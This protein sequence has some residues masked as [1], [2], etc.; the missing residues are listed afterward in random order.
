MPRW[1]AL[2][3]I[4]LVACKQEPATQPPPREEPRP[5]AEAQTQAQAQAQA[6]AAAEA[7][8][9]KAKAEGPLAWIHD[10]YAAALA[11]AKARDLPLVLDLWAPWCHTCLS[12][13]QTV[14]TDPSFGP[15]AKRFVFAALDTDRDGNAAAVAK[16]PLSA[17]PTFYVVSPEE[18]VLA[19]FTGAASVAQFHAFLD[20][21]AR[22]RGGG[23]AGA[24]AHLLAAERAIAAKD[25]EAAD[26]ELTAALAA[27]PADWARR[28]DALVSL[29]GAKHKRGDIEGCV[30]LAERS[31]NDT[32]S[33]ASAT[34]FLYHAGECAEA[35]GKPAQEGARPDAAAAAR[36]KKLRQAAVTRWQKLVDDPA[37]PLSIDDRSDA[38][39]N[40]RTMLLALDRKAEAKAVAER[41][42]QLLD[43]TAAKAPTPLAAMTY[44]WPRAEV[45]AFLE[46]PL[47]LVPALEKSVRDL[48]AEYDPPA[49]LG[50]IYLKGGKLDLAAQWTDA[51]LK[52]VYGP[53]KGRVLTQRAEI[54]AK[55]GDRA[56]ERAARAELVKTLEALPPGQTTPQAIEKAK[57]AL[58][59]LD[60]P[61]P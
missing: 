38:M 35:L 22:A 52:L 50:W 42:R 58:A 20:A 12:M 43:D 60:R 37:A 2:V 57:Q 25:L 56:A 32:G 23:A 30:A 45:Y 59:D 11:C 53:R 36:V 51:A 31:L 28:P 8:C 6:K 10:D 1:L 3:P 44:N 26:R 14:F 61:T 18:A 34:D 49:R 27:A 54:A 39:A 40:L 24:D 7:A 19:R 46:R 29:I 16:F 13:Q 55:A 47:D 41:Q 9:G 33:A 4:A 5:A 17:W 48:P 21:G 15:D